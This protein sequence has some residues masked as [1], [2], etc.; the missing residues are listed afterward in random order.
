MSGH[1]TQHAIER[2]IERIATDKIVTD[3]LDDS[4]ADM[5]FA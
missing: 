5:P 2:A 1:V 3:A 4:L